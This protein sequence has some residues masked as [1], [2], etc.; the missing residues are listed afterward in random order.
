MSVALCSICRVSATSEHLSSDWHKFNE[1]TTAEGKTPMAQSLYE[2]FEKSR[3]AGGALSPAT[4]EATPSKSPSS[5]TKNVNQWHWEE[6]NIAGWAFERLE[7]LIKESTFPIQAG[8]VL[9]ISAVKEIEGDAYLN[10]R[11]GKLR[12]GF[13]LKCKLEWEGEIKSDDGTSVVKANGKG[14]VGEIDDSTD[15]DEYAA[16]I[17]GF[18]MEKTDEKG[19][20]LLLTTIKKLGPK[21]ISKQISKL[22]KEMMAKKDEQPN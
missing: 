15:E 13:D 11:K 2:Q 7:T 18:T 3:F 6:K 22:V 1:K 4:S 20:E 10:L 19:A 5:N 8:A 17:S 9:R 21:V 12:V 16:Q 14:V